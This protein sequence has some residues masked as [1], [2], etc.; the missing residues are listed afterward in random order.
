MELDKLFTELWKNLYKPFVF[1]IPLRLMPDLKHNEVLNTV[2]FIDSK[3]FDSELKEA[4]SHHY[5]LSKAMILNDNIFK[6]IDQSERLPKQQFEF[7]LEKYLE[8]V[9]FVLYASNWMK[10]HV[11]IDISDLK[12][13]T[14]K[15]FKSQ[16][17]IFLQHVKDLESHIVLPKKIIENQEVDVSRFIKSDLS[18]IKNALNIKLDLEAPKT[19]LK[20]DEPTSIKIKKKL[21]L[22]CEEVAEDFLLETVFHIRKE[23]TTK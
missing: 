18:D 10:N 13:E 1:Y 20:K 6:L 9:N 19:S 11:E 23:C 12:E 7:F 15:S 21:P 8:H 22:I 5:I 16:T 4:P 3:G 14:K 17:E 2:I